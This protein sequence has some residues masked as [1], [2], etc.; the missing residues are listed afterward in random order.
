MVTKVAGMM[1][2]QAQS[3]HQTEIEKAK[4]NAKH[5]DTRAKETH[6]LNLVWRC[7]AQSRRRAA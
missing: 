5:L 2:V 3:L 4:I 6:T 7:H 1:G